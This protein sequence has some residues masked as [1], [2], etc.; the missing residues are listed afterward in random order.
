MELGSIQE[1]LI[2]KENIFEW[3]PCQ[4]QDR[5]RV[6]DRPDQEHLTRSHRDLRYSGARAQLLLQLKRDVGQE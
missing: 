6:N 4:A 1:K 3:K 5:G 2:P